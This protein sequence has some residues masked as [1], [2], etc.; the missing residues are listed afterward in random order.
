M[1]PGIQGLSCHVP[2]NGLWSP[3]HRPQP[4]SEPPEATLP[5]LSA[6]EGEALGGTVLLASGFLPEVQAP[7]GLAHLSPASSSGGSLGVVPLVLTRASLTRAFSV[8]GRQDEKDQALPLSGGLKQVIGPFR[9]ICG[10]GI[11]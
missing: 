11:T 8:G 7:D 1:F 4:L 6:G 5:C 2:A 3:G 10:P 9:P